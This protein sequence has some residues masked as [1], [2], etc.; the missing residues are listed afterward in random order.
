MPAVALVKICGLTRESDIEAA[1]SAGADR[2]G[3]VLV[4]ASPRYV[5]PDAAIT[6]TSLAGSGR[7]G[8]AGATAPEVWVIAEWAPSANRITE[9]LE[10]LL[11][12]DTG[13]SV[14][15]LH[16]KETP[17][18]VADLR[19]RAPSHVQVWKAI[20]VSTRDDLAQLARFGAADGFVLDAKPPP[21]A[22]REGGFGHPFDWTILDGFEPGRPWMLSGG[23]TVETVAAAIRISGAGAVDVSSGVEASPGV[24]DPAKVKAF[25]EAAKAAG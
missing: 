19:R 2:I 20:G 24:K 7:F 11:T 9:G 23:L 10:S 13:L 25:I 16:G 15:Q 21:G 12:P 1:V 8:K 5:A 6:W 17:E 4:P 18:D 3:F 22:A 14:V